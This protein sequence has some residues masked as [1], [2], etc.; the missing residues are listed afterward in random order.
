[1]RLKKLFPG[2]RGHGGIC[3]LGPTPSGRMILENFRANGREVDCF[4]D[5]QGKF[6]GDS[7]AGLL[8]QGVNH[9]QAHLV[10]DGL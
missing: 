8:R 10:A 3:I 2:R 6:R 4:V 9:F 5:P 1:M 7:W